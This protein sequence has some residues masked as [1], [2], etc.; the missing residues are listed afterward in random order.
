M[1]I[2]FVLVPLGLLFVVAAIGAFFWAVEHEQFEDL[3]A[4]ASRILVDD[5]DQPASNSR[6]REAI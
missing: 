4:Q 5:G 2:I 3:D 6:T 1:T